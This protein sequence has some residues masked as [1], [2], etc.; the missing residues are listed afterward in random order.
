MK[1]TLVLTT[2]LSASLRIV[3]VA[4]S[5]PTNW[6]EKADTPM[7][8]ALA[9]VADAKPTMAQTAMVYLLVIFI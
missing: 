7:V 8:V 5:T 4:R 6:G 3:A 9:D 2:L 1:A